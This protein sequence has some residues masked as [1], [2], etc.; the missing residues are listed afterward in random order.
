M[1]TA[2]QQGATTIEPIAKVLLSICGV[3]DAMACFSVY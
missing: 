1:G 3:L 2:L